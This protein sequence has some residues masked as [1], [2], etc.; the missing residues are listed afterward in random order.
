MVGVIIVVY[1]CRYNDDPHGIFAVFTGLQSVRVN[2]DMTRSALVNITRQQ[3]QYGMVRV[4]FTLV[5]DQVSHLVHSFLF[6]DNVASLFFKR[7][8]KNEKWSMTN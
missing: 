2:P 4:G 7:S 5:Y 3:G 6:F 1:C 8:I